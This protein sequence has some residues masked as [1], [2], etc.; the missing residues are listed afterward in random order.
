[1][2]G[3]ADPTSGR[4]V[5]VASVLDRAAERLESELE[6]SPTSRSSLRLTLGQTYQGL[7]LLEP[8]EHLVRTALA[9]RL[10]RHGA[11]RAGCGTGSR[12]PGEHPP[13]PRGPREAEAS[14][15]EVIATFDRIG[16]GDSTRPSPPAPASLSR[17]R[18]WGASTRRRCSTA[19]SSR[20]SDGGSRENDRPGGGRDRQQPR[21]GARPAG[22]LAWGRGAAPGGPRDHPRVQGPRASRRG[23]GAARPLGAAMESQGDLAGAEASTGES[24]GPRRALLGAEHPDVTSARAYALA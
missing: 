9:R 14:A 11:G 10:E 18:T 23:F 21:R 6:A 7:G 24:L 17:C 2:L 4:E 5:T 16:E 20:A 1:M 8:A 22:G 12:G 19:R 13:G 3:S 15:R